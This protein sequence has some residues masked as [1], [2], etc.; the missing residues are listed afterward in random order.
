MIRDVNGSNNSL[1]SNATRTNK[2]SSNVDTG[3]NNS[4]EAKSSGKGSDTVSL[5]A[6]AQLLGQVKDIVAK[7]PDV[8][9]ARVEQFKTAIANGEYQIDNESVANK[10]LDT[11]KR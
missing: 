11:D 8:D 1:N 5:S 4:T 9:M 6:E 3:S 10:I 2:S 7:L